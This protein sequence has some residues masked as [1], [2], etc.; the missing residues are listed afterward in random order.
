MENNTAGPQK[1]KAEGPAVHQTTKYLSERT[2]IRTS[3]VLSLPCLLQCHSYESNYGKNS[4]AVERVKT[5][6][7][8][9][10]NVVW[11]LLGAGGG[12]MSKCLITLGRSS[13]TSQ[14]NDSNPK[15][16]RRKTTDHYHHDKI[17]KASN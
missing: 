6:S 4:D 5:W 3:Q 7:I 9:P 8:S 14:T 16:A 1:G 12:G 15:G 17:T 10:L 13:M 2:G 11:L